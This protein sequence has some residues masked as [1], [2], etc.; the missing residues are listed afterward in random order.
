MCI[1]KE[2]KWRHHSSNLH[3]RKTSISLKQ[4]KI[5]QK[6]KCHSSVFSKAFQIRRKYFSCLRHFNLN[7][8]ETAENIHIVYMKYFGLYWQ[9]NL[10]TLHP[11]LSLEKRHHWLFPPRGNVFTDFKDTRLYFHRINPYFKTHVLQNIR[12]Y[13]LLTWSWSSVKTTRW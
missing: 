13:S 6:E 10:L 7:M 9:K 3:N 8:G 4:K 5:F 12:S 2:T 1:I 11:G